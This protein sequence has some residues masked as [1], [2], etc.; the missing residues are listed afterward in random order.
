MRS[1][2]VVENTTRWPFAI[3]EV[4]VVPARTYLRDGRYADMRNTAVYNVCRHYGYQQVGYYVSLLAAARG[5]RPLPS[6]ETLQRLKLAPVI[7][8]LADDLE[9]LIRRAL[10]PLKSDEFELSVYFGRNPAKRYDRLGQA[11]FNQF[12]AP[13]LRATFARDGRWRLVTVRAV[14]TSEIPDAHREFVLDRA[15][16]FF[17]RPARAR[18]AVRS[19][20]YDLAILWSDQDD[21]APSDE[22]A[23]RRFQ[24]AARPIGL[25]ATIVGPDDYGRI[26]EYDALFIR[27]TTRINHHTFRFAQRA[28]HEGMVV[29]D[30]PT[31]IVR[32]TN[33]VYQAELFERH[34]IPAPPTVLLQEGDPLELVRPLGLPLVLKRPDSSFSEGVVKVNTPDELAARLPEFF[35]D[36]ELVVA[37]AFTPTDFDWRI[38]VLD[39]APLFACRYHMAR[40]HWQIIA[41]QVR[42]RYGR[43]EAVPLGDVPRR[44]LTLAVRAASLIGNGLYGID[45]KVMGRR[46]LVTEVNDNPS[47]EAGYEDRAAG[48]DLYRAIMAWFRRELDRR[49]ETAGR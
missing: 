6:V 30:D 18:R 37:Q 13:F 24:R 45:L 33:K 35:A 44:V 29:I 3:P 40:G 36:S 15:T 28:A 2:V 16:A 26:A 34:D 48:L 49:G 12:P 8:T 17:R 22:R 43:V 19:H 39:G 14:A 23:I 31:S 5:H 42:K 20:H 11:L 4:E 46:V 21:D 47:I 32:C 41:G 7:R 1:L 38:G 9:G 10:A 27:Q 25:E